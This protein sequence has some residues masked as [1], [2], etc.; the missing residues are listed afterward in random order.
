MIKKP[1]RWAFFSYVQNLG[2]FTRA[3]ETAKGMK[4][5]GGIVKFFNHGK[6]YKDLI[7]E[8]GIE[9]EVL[10]PTIS[11]EQDKII[12]ILDGI[13]ISYIFISHNMDFIDQTTDKIYGMANG[14]ISLEK[15]KVPHTH[16]HSHGHGR[17]PHTHIEENKK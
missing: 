1:L 15:E 9:A 10:M 3:L 2:D 14:Q 8:T 12:G 13:D 11:K 17:L 7:E 5:S 16:V 4:L 6:E